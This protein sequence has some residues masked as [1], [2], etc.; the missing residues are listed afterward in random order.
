[1]A[2]DI[3]RPSCTN[4]SRKPFTDP[5]ISARDKAKKVLQQLKNLTLKIYHNSEH[6]N[7]NQVIQSITAQLQPDTIS[8]EH[9]AKKIK[10]N[11]DNILDNNMDEIS[12]LYDELQSDNKTFIV[13][14]LNCWGSRKANLFNEP[15]SSP[16]FAN[17]YL[18]NHITGIINHSSRTITEIKDQ[19][20]MTK[21]WMYQS[22]HGQ[23]SINNNCIVFDKEN[24]AIACRQ[25][26]FWFLWN[27]AIYSNNLLNLGIMSENIASLDYNDYDNL[28]CVRNFNHLSAAPLDQLGILLQEE[29]KNM[30]PGEKKH[31]LFYTENHAMAFKIYYKT[32]GYFTV[33]FYDPNKTTVHTCLVMSSSDDLQYLSI[34]H[35]LTVESSNCYFPKFKSFV[36]A[37]YDQVNLEPPLT[38]SFNF[39]SITQAKLIEHEG[40]F[41]IAMAYGNKNY[42]RDFINVVINSKE[43]NIQKKLE[44]LSAKNYNSVS[45]L[46]I[47]FCAGHAETV[48]AFTNSIL[49]SNALDKP[50]K[51]ALLSAKDHD[52]FSGLYVA[53]CIGHAETVTAFT[54][55]ILNSTVLSEQEKVELL[56]AK[57]SN[58]VSGLYVAFC[59]GHAETVTAFTNSI[60][61]SNALD[62]PQKLELLSTKDHDSC[63]GLYIAFCIGHAET[64]T[65]FTN[66]ILNSTVLSEQEKVEL[67]S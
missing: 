26:S 51:L 50:Q 5:N 64:V 1:M 19:N 9:K 59:A 58:D 39:P 47:A 8:Y 63:S 42:V 61:N 3:Q 35:L 11:P 37:S 10:L 32:L 12:S 65:A 57:N 2:I 18:Y 33:K 17:Y 49:N 45:G 30:T 14:E 4:Q 44:L 48:T 52:S 13:Q 29:C 27:D 46:Y 28:N 25:L 66:S 22:K 34:T 15:N 6:K 20:H 38:Q 7:I 36:L 21:I 31:L 43:L 54:N 67:L 53:F 41:Y 23:S 24:K 16:A 40:L 60:L 62:K 55:S 56:S